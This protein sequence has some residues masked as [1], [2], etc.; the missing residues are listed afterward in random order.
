MSKRILAAYFSA[1]GVIAKA[2]WKLAET[3]GAELYEIKPEVSYAHADLNWTDK[4]V[5]VQ[6]K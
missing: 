3:V 5:E 1:N 6:S 4:K 2:A